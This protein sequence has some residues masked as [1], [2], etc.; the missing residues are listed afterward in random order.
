MDSCM[1]CNL[2]PFLKILKLIITILQW[3]VPL[4]LVV[5]GTVDMF[6][7]VAKADDD[8]VVKDARG[9]FIKRLIYGALIFLVPFLV[10]VILRLVDDHIIQN[11]D[12]TG[13]MS[14]VSC[15][16]SSEASACSGCSD[17][18][19]PSGDVNNQ[20]SGGNTNVGGNTGGNTTGQVVCYSWDEYDTNCS[21]STIDPH[22][23]EFTNIRYSSDGYCDATTKISETGLRTL[24]WYQNLCESVGFIKQYHIDNYGNFICSF[25]TNVQKKYSTSMPTNAFGGYETKVC[26]TASYCNAAY[27][28]L[29]N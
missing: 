29:C 13:P 26:S 22:R 8:K 21:N 17:I 15:F 28:E 12:L 16:N 1:C 19:A 4:L 7:A 3:S 23:S 14:W 6:K 10:R 2:Q 27:Y 18:Y 11:D 5:L 20:G 9:S 24:E 25:K